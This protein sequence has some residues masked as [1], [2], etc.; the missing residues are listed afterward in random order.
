[1]LPRVLQKSNAS[2]Y[3]FVFL[4][5]QTSNTVKLRENRVR[6]TIPPWNRK[7]RPVAPQG[8]MWVW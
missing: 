2:L 4:I 6:H 7:I 5:I 3:G 8:N 1:M